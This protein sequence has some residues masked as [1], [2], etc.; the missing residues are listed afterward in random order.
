MHRL[1]LRSTL[2][3]TLCSALLAA[4]TLSPQVAASQN[5]LPLPS[6]S[7]T[8]AD[9]AALP[10]KV[11]ETFDFRLQVKWGFISGSGKASFAVEALE[12]VRGHQTLRL[13][14][15]T[16]GSVAVFGI[17]DLQRSWLDTRTLFARRFEQ[18]LDQTGYKRD[19]T[20]D[21]LPEQMQY[22]NIA[23]AADSGTLASNI[24][25]DDVSFIYF[26]RTL[27][28]KVGD[29]YT[30][31]RYYKADGNPVSVRVLRTERITV[32]AGSFDAVVVKPIIR[33]KGLFSEGGN[34]EV[35]FSNDARHIPLRV[36]AK[37]SVATLTMELQTMTVP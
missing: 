15:R 5:A 9:A 27:P 11:G 14:F 36:R 30:A 33:T 21:F 20:Y 16:R 10:F 17:N 13:A 22:V 37:V 23:N 1:I 19:K 35:W 18:K 2:R 32:P 8:R 4:L 26:I 28:L 3:S 25:L 12:R 7:N 24:P 34:A 6:T 31:S 29:V